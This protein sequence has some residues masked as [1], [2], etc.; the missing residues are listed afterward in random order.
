MPRRSTG[1]IA[2]DLKRH[3]LAQ[4]AAAGFTEYLEPFTGEPLGSDAQSWTA[5]VVLDWLAS[6]S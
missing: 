2:A 6:S 3:A 5:A 1:Q 4:V